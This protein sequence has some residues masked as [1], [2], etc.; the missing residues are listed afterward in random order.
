MDNPTLVVRRSLNY[1]VAV[2]GDQLKQVKGL[3][4]LLQLQVEL[5]GQSCLVVAD[6]AA[7]KPTQIHIVVLYFL[8]LDEQKRLND[9]HQNITFR[10]SHRYSV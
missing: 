5:P 4:R 3:G 1:L 9:R 2:V 8:V 7:R 10:Q 6:V